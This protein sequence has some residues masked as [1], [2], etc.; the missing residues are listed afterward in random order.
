MKI[1]TLLLAG[2]GAFCCTSTMAQSSATLAVGDQVTEVANITPSTVAYRIKGARGYLFSQSAEATTL[3]SNY[4][5]GAQSSFT[6][7]EDTNNDP[8]FNFVLIP[9]PCKPIAC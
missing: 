8:N 6:V 3:S 9:S 5:R 1:S 7:P 2:V 4:L